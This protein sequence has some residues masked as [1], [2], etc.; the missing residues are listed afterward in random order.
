MVTTCHQVTMS[1]TLTFPSPLALLPVP[2]ALPR[3]V[4]GA[5]SALATLPL[6]RSPYLV[7]PKPDPASP[8]SLS[9]MLFWAELEEDTLR[10]LQGQ[11]AG[12]L[13]AEGSLRALAAAVLAACS[14]AAVA[15]SA[16]EDEGAAAAE[17]CTA[18]GVVLGVAMRTV[19]RAPAAAAAA[20]EIRSLRQGEKR[21]DNWELLAEACC[22]CPRTICGAICQL[23]RCLRGCCQECC[24]GDGGD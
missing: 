16:K 9:L 21:E 5:L 2:A 3:A 23:L 19:S 11:L 18:T 10:V 8:G 7:V 13:A 6:S 20:L 14:A 4:C 12:L 15:G 24:V 17:G 22:L 1:F